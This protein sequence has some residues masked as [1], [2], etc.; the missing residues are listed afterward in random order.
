MLKNILLLYILLL[1]IHLK[2]KGNS[3]KGLHVCEFVE[4]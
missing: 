4:K 1:Y 2:I 3:E